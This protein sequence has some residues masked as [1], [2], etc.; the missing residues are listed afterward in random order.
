MEPHREGEAMIP[1]A[2]G[3]PDRFDLGVTW[4]LV[5]F[6]FVTISPGKVHWNGQGWKQEAE[7]FVRSKREVMLA[8]SRRPVLEPARNRCVAA[9]SRD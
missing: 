1:C 8:C 6:F 7:A 9:C 3:A 5:L 2:G 4:P